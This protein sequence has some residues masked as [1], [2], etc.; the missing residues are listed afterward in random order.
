MM[1]NKDHAS[2]DPDV[3]HHLS[4]AYL[5]HQMARRI[6][7]TEDLWERAGQKPVAQ[8]IV[9]RKRGWIGHTLRKQ[10]SNSTRQALT[11]NPQV[12][13]REAPTSQEL[14]ARH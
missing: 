14:E 7:K 3:Y 11:W 1:D 12:R 8:K 6:K 13:G 2:K 4:E 9:R 10:V 5:Q